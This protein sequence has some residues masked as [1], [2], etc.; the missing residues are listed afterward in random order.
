MLG[1]HHSNQAR[2][3]QL[4]EIDSIGLPIDQQIAYLKS[5][6]DPTSVNRVLWS[7]IL[8]HEKAFA[9]VCRR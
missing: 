6:T 5:R 8:R 9:Q 2:L 1:A 7:S 4:C 3:A